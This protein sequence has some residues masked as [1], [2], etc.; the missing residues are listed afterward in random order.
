ML[1]TFL[2]TWYISAFWTT[3]D[4]SSIHLLYQSLAQVAKVLWK[5]IHAI[6]WEYC[7]YFTVIF[8]VVIFKIYN[9]Y[10]KILTQND[11]WGRKLL[12]ARSDSRRN[13]ILYAKPEGTNKAIKTLLLKKI[14]YKSTKVIYIQ[15]KLP[16]CYKLH[17]SCMLHVLST[18]TIAILVLGILSADILLELWNSQLFL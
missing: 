4:F 15:Y 2:L 7:I 1:F 11:F 9:I 18:C 8:N 16:Q 12:L 13:I 5:I 6:S 3:Q 10:W 17:M 14:T